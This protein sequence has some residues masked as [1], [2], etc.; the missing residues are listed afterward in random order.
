[1]TVDHFGDLL[2]TVEPCVDLPIPLIQ[3]MGQS[4]DIFSD[5]RFERHERVLFV[6]SDTQQADG[7][8]PHQ[9]LIDLGVTIINCFVTD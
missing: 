7:S 4:L 9:K 6:L 5:P 8:Y 2:K 3:A 1:M